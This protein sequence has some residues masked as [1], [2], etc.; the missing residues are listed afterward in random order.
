MSSVEK[1]EEA[2]I[3][4]RD[5]LALSEKV[6][7]YNHE[8]TTWCVQ[9]LAFALCRQEKY[10]QA[11]SL[12]REQLLIRGQVPE[13]DLADVPSISILTIMTELSNVF[14]DLGKYKEAL[15]LLKKMLVGWRKVVG[16]NHPGTL[17]TL[18]DLGKACE[19]L[20][21]FKESEKHYRQVMETRRS[22]LGDDNK[23]VLQSAHRLGKVLKQQESDEKRKEAEEILRQ[24]VSK[25]EIVLGKFHKDTLA[26]A[27]ALGH[28]LLKRKC[29]QEAETWFR[30]VLTG[31]EETLGESHKSTL[32]ARDDLEDVLCEQRKWP[33]L[34]ESCRYSLAL[35]RKLGPENDDTLRIAAY[36]GGALMNIGNGEGVALLDE[37]ILK[38]QGFHSTYREQ[39]NLKEAVLAKEREYGTS[40]IRFGLR[41][42]Q[43]ME[44]LKTLALMHDETGKYDAADYAFGF[45][46]DDMEATWGS[47]DR[48]SLDLKAE[49]AQLLDKQGKH[50]KAAQLRKQS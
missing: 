14:Y 9:N 50:D 36:L 10:E 18:Q 6:L 17:N 27:S 12:L 11:E 7:G 3:I 29:Y 43:T 45:L 20:K 16:D 24:V 23:L 19:E 39:G 41:G 13:A 1:Y 48:R 33:E 5:Q 44:V 42:P 4:Q 32:Y 34:V 8:I 46:I 40:I 31:T 2:E 15:F 37:V 49:F 25:R 21:D 22:L 38:A 26:S 35:R 30:R 47:H 28:T